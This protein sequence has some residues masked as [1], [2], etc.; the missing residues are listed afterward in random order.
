[1]HLLSSWS[2]MAAS[3]EA[4]AVASLAMQPHRWRYLLAFPSA[5]T[6]ASP[7]VSRTSVS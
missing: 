4:F 2:T 5:Y 7:L 1:M 6:G 3:V